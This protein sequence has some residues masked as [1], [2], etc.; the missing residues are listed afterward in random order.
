MSSRKRESNERSFLIVA[1][2]AQI[3]QEYGEKLMKLSQLSLSEFEEPQTS[4]SE[5]LES[6]PIATEA[7]ARAHT[8][9]AQQ[10]H[11]LL[12]S[13]LASFIKDQKSLRKAVRHGID[14]HL[15]ILLMFI[16]HCHT[17]LDNRA[18]R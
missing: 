15:E 14:A 5:I 3:E 12:E 13:P 6:V 16:C 4:M 11:H 10:I 17:K 7:T 9:L 2:R 8:D 18:D 1:D